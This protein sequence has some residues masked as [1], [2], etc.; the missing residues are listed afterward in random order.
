MNA[1]VKALFASTFAAFLFLLPTLAMDNTSSSNNW[2]TAETARLRLHEKRLALLREKYGI[3]PAFI[4]YQQMEEMLIKR[5]S[6]NLEAGLQAP[7]PAPG[8]HLEAYF[9]KPD[10]SPQPFWT[11]VPEK[12]AEHPGLLLHLHGY[13]PT[14]DLLIVPCVPAAFTNFAEATGS[15][16]A[17]PFSHGNTD[18]QHLGEADVL[19]VIDEMVARYGVDRDKV[20]LTGTSM[21]GLGA[22][23]IAARWPQLFN[24]VVIDSGRADFYVWHRLQPED[25]P[26]WQR[27]IVD[28]I[29]A[30]R[31]L[32]A[33]TD[34]SV[35]AGHGYFDDIVSYDQGAFPVNQLKKLGAKHVRLH[36]YL[37]GHGVFGDLFSERDV[38][39]LLARALTEKLPRGNR[40][41]SIPSYPGQTGFR[42]MDAL[43]SPFVLVAGR[44]R[45]GGGY[46]EDKLN[47]RAGEWERFSHGRPET[48]L[49]TALTKGTA[50]SR[51]LILFGEPETSPLIKAFLNRA[52]VTYTKDAFAIEGHV[53][54]RS[55]RHGFIIALPNPFE[56]RHTAIV[57]CG[58]PW[59]LTG[60][61]NHRF[62]RIPDLAGYQDENDEF[63]YPLVDTAAFLTPSNTYRFVGT[64][65]K[66]IDQSSLPF[67]DKYLFPSEEPAENSR[68]SSSG[69]T[70]PPFSN[71]EEQLP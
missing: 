49:E 12:P 53:I 33:L 27:E 39:R 54:P 45:N 21:G 65:P 6:A 23:C 47:E 25:I 18:F 40:T 70:P 50:G 36:S 61:D 52:G 66:R 7:S 13:D 15:Y 48:V 44:D 30:G 26:E 69:D 55:A 14:L 64:E 51:N 56:P 17:S 19:R 42:L 28:S 38:Q 41:T 16:L 43:L 20:V 22:W 5:I 9:S 11:Y 10:G 2:R 67:Y 32:S 68:E 34:S 3:Y 37:K 46:S 71:S 24:A 58:V 62:D 29:F 8:C 35:I 59:A 63:G 1:H 57:Q 60:A 4:V 31:R